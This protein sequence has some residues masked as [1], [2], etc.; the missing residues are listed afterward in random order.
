MG[1]YLGRLYLN[2]NR[3]PQYVER[4]VLTEP[5]EDHA[6]SGPARMVAPSASEERTPPG[7]DVT[8]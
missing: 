7:Q 3:K 6:P 4:T 5:D 8:G 1:E 2:V